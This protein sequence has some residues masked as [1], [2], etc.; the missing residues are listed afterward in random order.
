MG[1]IFHCFGAR[2][3]VVLLAA[4]ILTGPARAADNMSLGEPRYVFL[5]PVVVSVMRDARVRG[6][7]T[8]D[9]GL[10]VRDA[11]TREEIERAMPRLRDRYIQALTYLASNRID[12]SRPVDVGALGD[13]LQSVTDSVLGAKAARVLVSGATVRRL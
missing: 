5:E 10:E 13:M 4:L 2:I 12:V 7:L 9:V 6:L 8:V 1:R 3:A 11:D